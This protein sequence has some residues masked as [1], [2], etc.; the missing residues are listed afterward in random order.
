MDLTIQ[1]EIFKNI[2][3]HHAI[4]LKFGSRFFTSLNMLWCEA[5]ASICSAIK[6]NLILYYCKLSAFVVSNINWYVLISS[7]SQKTPF[8]K[9]WLEKGDF[10]LYFY[11]N[12]LKIH[13]KLAVLCTYNPYFYRQKSYLSKSKSTSR[14]ILVL[15][16]KKSKIECLNQKVLQKRRTKWKVGSELCRFLKGV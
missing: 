12:H 7:V 1:M 14:I 8:V 16:L 5:K 2:K 9:D 15:K 11:Q 4:C 6:E 10:K 13:L 3:P